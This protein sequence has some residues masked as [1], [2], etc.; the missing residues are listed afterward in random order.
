M[1]SDLSRLLFPSPTRKIPGR[2]WVKIL[3][4]AIHVCFVCGLVGLF[5][6]HERL[7]QFWLV[8]TGC[9]GAAILL[10]DLHASAVF[11]LQVRGLIVLTKIAAFFTLPA[12]GASAL[13]VLF[14]LVILS[15]V[16][17]HASSGFRYY[18]IFGRGR[19]TT[20]EDKG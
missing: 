11:L 3:L 17:S 14:A 10:L 1:A 9:S 15:V 5:V 16:S 6:A 2:R 7:D 8:G 13:W 12:L 19:L 18:L 20:V 4:R